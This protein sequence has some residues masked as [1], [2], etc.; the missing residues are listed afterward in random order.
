MRKS[1]LAGAEL[2]ITTIGVAGTA[3]ASPIRECGNSSDGWGSPVEVVNPT[4][5]G[6]ARS[7][8]R[9][10]AVRVTGRYPGVSLPTPERHPLVPSRM[11]LTPGA[12]SRVPSAG[13]GRC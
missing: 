1:L 5:R 4:T 6:V 2:V 8:A 3:S 12:L 13:L 10:Y 9:H 11:T 7:F